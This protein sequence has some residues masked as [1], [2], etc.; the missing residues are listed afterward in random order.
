[1][2]KL[3]YR[4]ATFLLA[5]WGAS[6][7]ELVAL[8][9]PQDDVRDASADLSPRDAYDASLDSAD[10]AGR[11]VIASDRKDS[12]E[13]DRS[14]DDDAPLAD[15]EDVSSDDAPSHDADGSGDP[16]G[17]KC[18]GTCNAGRCLVLLAVGPPEHAY[19]MALNATHIYWTTYM[20]MKDTLKRAPLDGSQ[21][22]VEMAT[23]LPSPHAIVL[24]GASVYWTNFL[25]GTG[26]VMK[27][28]LDGVLGDSMTTLT[29]S[30]NF[31]HHLVISGSELF[32]TN[33]SAYP[34]GAIVKM[35][36]DGTGFTILADRQ[37]HPTNL[38]VDATHVYWTD[39]GDL[40]FVMKGPREGGAGVQVVGGQRKPYGVAVDATN[41]Y[42]TSTQDGSV[43]KK[44]LAGGDPQLLAAAAGDQAY[45]LTVDE[46]YVYWTT[47]GTAA[48]GTA[49]VGA[50]KKVPIAGGEVTTLTT[51]SRSHN[52]VVDATS[53][54]FTNYLDGNVYKLT[55]K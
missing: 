52:V 1:L 2:P 7:S 17:P 25:P 51:Q 22:I 50:I 53:V 3:T 37:D 26:A 5:T 4:S 14:Y 41:L 31:Y 39:W 34:G 12:A 9:T 33:Y 47:F 46:T 35:R 8:P 24:D 40:G 21:Q 15:A 28:P 55:P 23:N 48:N 54:Y 42:W 32:F 38:A 13:S 30:P 6:C 16:C 45:N 11:D 10:P 19:G 49:D 27:M 18:I 43:M 29:P 36:T 44:P 20:A